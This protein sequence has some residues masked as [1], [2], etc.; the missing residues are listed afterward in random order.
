MVQCLYA[1]DSWIAGSGSEMM[2]SVK[3]PAALCRLVPTAT[4]IP[5]CWE[6]VKLFFYPGKNTCQE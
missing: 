6:S 3:L 4:R 2:Q 5:A 1:L